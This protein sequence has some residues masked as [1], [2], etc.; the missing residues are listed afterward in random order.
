M[1]QKENYTIYNGDS[2]EVM[3]QL[4]DDNIKVD[5]VLNG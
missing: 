5:F 4:S 3:K 1:I 2:L